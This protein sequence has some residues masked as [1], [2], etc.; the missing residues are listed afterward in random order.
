[1]GYLTYKL[2]SLLIAAINLLVCKFAKGVCLN[3][4]GCNVAL[5]TVVQ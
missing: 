1:M 4:A 2:K 3:Q 5:E